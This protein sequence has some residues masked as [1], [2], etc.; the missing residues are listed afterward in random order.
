MTCSAA[1]E[2]VNRF[3][4]IFLDQTERSETHR[5]L[6]DDQSVS[7][8]WNTDR[9]NP[10]NLMDDFIGEKVIIKPYRE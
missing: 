1:L 10:W 6:F 8:G 4:S 3:K 7:G 2:S 9:R 5:L